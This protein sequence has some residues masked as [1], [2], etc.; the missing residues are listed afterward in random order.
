MGE[1]ISVGMSQVSMMSLIANGTPAS[2][3]RAPL[4]SRARACAI[5]CSGFRYCHASPLGSRSSM[6]S[7]PAR[8]TA[9]HVVCPEAT[10]A[11]I[12]V[13]VSSFSGVV[14]LRAGSVIVVSYRSLGK[15]KG[16]YKLTPDTILPGLQ[17]LM[18]SN[19]TAGPQR[20][21]FLLA[22]CALGIAQITAWGTSYYCLG[23]LAGPI[24]AE[25]GWSR[26]LVYFGFTVSLL[27]MGAV[28]AW[29]GR[30]I[31]RHGA[32]AIMTAGTVIVSLG[33]YALS[34]VTSEWTYLAVWVVLGVGMR[35]CLYDAAFAALVQILPA[36]GRRAASDLTLYGAFASAAFAGPGRPL[37]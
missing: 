20:D 5:T 9:S 24:V 17:N 4:R 27:A 12:S 28:S 21:P 7:S 30:A 6:R 18:S 10:A 33:L 36:R 3:P 35:L 11:A 34:L 26:S 19:M 16:E 31:D 37:S 15:F 2:G 29:A 22:V 23:V 1:P 8:T 32:R 25:T 14:G 13:A